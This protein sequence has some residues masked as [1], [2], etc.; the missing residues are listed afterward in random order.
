MPA[1]APLFRAIGLGKHYAT[2]VLADVDLDLQAGEVL[3]LTGE[4]GAGKSTLSKIVAGLVQPTTGTMT[5]GGAPYAPASR[6]AA[7]RAGVRMVLQELSLVPTLTVAENLL[8]ERL[9]SRLGFIRRDALRAS[10]LK[11]M[12]AL[13]LHDIDPDRPVGSLGVGH[14]QMIEIARS[15]VGE[16]RL[17]ILDEPTATLTSREIDHLFAQIAE[18]KARG[19]AIVYISHRLDELQRIADRVMVLRDG[20]HIDTQPMKSLSHEAIVRRMVGRDVHEAFDRPRRTAGPVALRVRGLARGQA[21]RDVDLELRRGEVY[22]LA[23]LVGSGRT[24]LLRLIYGA[25]R[26]DRGE[27]YLD[28][29]DVPARIASPMRAVRAGIGLV[30]EDR[31][32]QGLLLPL[33]I[34]INTTLA[35]LEA[36]ARAGWLRTG[37][38]QRAVE[39]LRGAL[40][41]RSL[42]TEQP[43]GEL[44]GGNQQ[45]VVFARWLH[46]DCRVLLLDEPTRGVDIGARADIYAEMDKLAAAGK[47]LLMVSSDLREL[48]MVCDRIG[49]MSAGR[50]VA[51]FERGAWTQEAL[52]AAAFSAYAQAA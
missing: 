9:P 46:R 32:A 47:A 39:R 5:L 40:R 14:R 4:N 33:S 51:T 38:E 44:S 6:T 35:N 26:E 7:E 17:L 50:L 29:G 42:G 20:R 23:G 2:P 16:C 12:A 21:V 43:V 49:V 8:L 18:L 37:D 1:S 15:L 31:K 52:L 11:H 10:A 28:A 30:T 27:V 41:V 13:G 48:M 25:D 45:K 22:G 36:I 19:V 34:R 24:E 3:A